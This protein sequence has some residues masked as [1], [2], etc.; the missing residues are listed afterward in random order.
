MLSAGVG[1]GLFF[2]GTNH[3]AIKVMA[4]EPEHKLITTNPEEV[5]RLQEERR[6]RERGQI[7]IGKKE[8]SKPVYKPYIPPEPMD[9]FTTTSDNGGSN[10]SVS[11]P[12]IKK[13]VGDALKED[14]IVKEPLKVVE[15]EKKQVS[16]EPTVIEDNFKDKRPVNSPIE[17]QKDV[18]VL[19][20]N[21]DVKGDIP[22]KV[23]STTSK[24]TVEQQ[25]SV[26]I[27]KN[28]VDKKDE[29]AGAK[30]PLVENVSNATDS[31]VPKKKLDSRIVELRKRML[32]DDDFIN[33]GPTADEIMD[34]IHEMKNQQRNSSSQASTTGNISPGTKGS[35]NL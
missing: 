26:A 21:N 35:A 1:E 33:K 30:K 32:K 11:K 31:S 8:P 15:V 10:A 22:L 27:E 16:E 14:F 25:N 12:E 18:K 4:S 28:N 3:V 13:V 20:S 7:D 29:G 19:T 34:S 9:E 2:A 23:G 17:P 5:L 24:S 6:R